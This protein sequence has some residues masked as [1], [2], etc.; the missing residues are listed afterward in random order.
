MGS[1][2]SF[3]MRKGK[4]AGKDENL[5]KARDARL[6]SNFVTSKI[7]PGPAFLLTPENALM[8][9][10]A[11]EREGEKGRAGARLVLNV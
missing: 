1:F 3:H 6:R 4:R 2:F 8:R 11:K 9:L 5:R 7:K 10:K